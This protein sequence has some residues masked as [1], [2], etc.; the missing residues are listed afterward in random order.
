MEMTPNE[1]QEQART[2]AIYPHERGLEYVVLGLA[3]E[4]GEIAGKVKKLI[5]DGKDWNGDKREDNRQ[6]IIDELGDVVWYC[7]ELA[8]QC[9]VTLE[10]VMQ[11]NLDKLQSRQERN[12]LGGDGDNR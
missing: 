3:S 6:A 12:A 10:E 9:G 2:T 7:A 8:G 5:R 1:Y 11:R 4:S